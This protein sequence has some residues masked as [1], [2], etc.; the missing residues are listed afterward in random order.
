MDAGGQGSPESPNRAVEYLLELNNIIE[1]Q[2]KLLE[3]QRRRIEELEVQLDRLSQENKDLKLDRQPSSAAD[4]IT[5]GMANMAVGI[6]TGA[7]VSH[8]SSHSQTQPQIQAQ[9]QH[10]QQQHHQQHQPQ[11]PPPPIPIPIHP[12]QAHNNSVPIPAPPPPPPVPPRDRRTHITST[13]H[14]VATS[15]NTHHHTA[16]STNTHHHTVLNRVVSAGPVLME[17]ER[18]E[19]LANDTSSSASS[20][21]TLH[22]QPDG[23]SSKG[24]SVPFFFSL[25]L[26]PNSSVS[27]RQ[28]TRGSIALAGPAPAA[29]A[30]ATSAT[31]MATAAA[32]REGFL[33]LDDVWNQPSSESELSYDVPGKSGVGVGWVKLIP[34]VP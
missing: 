8:V 23:D 28:T 12:I 27:H 1:S 15:T 16:T 18:L 3:T 20:V 22:R 17:K 11:P 6:S 24:R 14:H 5:M 29:A 25:P 19:R 32:Q 9:I 34:P 26:Y 31:A 13:H 4:S 2:Q 10:H 30:T 7:V 21:A 33:N